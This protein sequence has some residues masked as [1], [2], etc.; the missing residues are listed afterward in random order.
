MDRTK[1]MFD[2]GLEPEILTVDNHAD[3][4]YVYMELL[5]EDPERAEEVL[6]LLQWNQGNSSGNG[7]GCI[8]WNGEVYADQFWRHFSLGNVLERPFSEIW[9]DVSGDTE[10]SDLMAK[11]KD[12]R[13]H[14]KGRCATCRGSRSA[15]ATSA[16]VPR[17]PPA[18][19]GTRTRPATSPTRRSCLCHCPNS[20]E[21][22]GCAC[23]PGS[24]AWS[25]KPFCGP[26]I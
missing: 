25:P 10:Q 17:R 9:T 20:T 2:D 15:A 13:P 4:P 3:G 16:C 1:A 14:V 26:R 6:Q 12:K 5:K 21:D 23:T 7:I 8:S 24:G 11:L 22:A 18:T 19:C